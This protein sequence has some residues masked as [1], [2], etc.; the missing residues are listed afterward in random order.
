MIH[1]TWILSWRSVLSS[2]TFVINELY[3]DSLFVFNPLTSQVTMQPYH[4]HFAMALSGAKH[5]VSLHPAST[6]GAFYLY[7]CANFSIV[8]ILR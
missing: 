7:T 6:H 8:V 3:V 2:D 5:I 1:P 4:H